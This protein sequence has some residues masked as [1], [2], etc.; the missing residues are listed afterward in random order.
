VE[1]WVV[2]FGGVNEGEEVNRGVKGWEVKSEL[3]WGSGNIRI[4]EKDFPHW[5]R[6]GV[7]RRELGKPGVN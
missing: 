5:R 1:G 6:G 4:T 2:F 3:K 7:G